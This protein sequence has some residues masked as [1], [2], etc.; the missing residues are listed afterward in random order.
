MTKAH[1]Q[2]LRATPT[3][4]LLETLA[5]QVVDDVY[6]AEAAPA[7][8]QVALHDPSQVSVDRASGLKDILA[9]I[10]SI[11]TTITQ[12]CPAS[13]A[14]MAKSIRNPSVLNRAALLNEIRSRGDLLGNR[15]RDI[16][17]SMLARGSAL[18]DQ[19]AAALVQE[20]ASPSNLLL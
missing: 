9:T 8:P 3:L 10:I 6:P 12:A 19:D 16:Y 11:F 14:S 7:A 18:S 20:A 5:G 15:P 2:E 1:D 4:S 13:A 17:R